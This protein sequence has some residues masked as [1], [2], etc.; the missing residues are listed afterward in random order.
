[1]PV[2]RDVVTLTPH[3]KNEAPS[4]KQ[5]PQRD[6][7]SLS[8]LPAL[9]PND[10]RQ[11]MLAQH[12]FPPEMLDMEYEDDDQV[13]A[14]LDA[15]D[16]SLPS[17]LSDVISHDVD[18]AAM[19]PRAAPAPKRAFPA[20]AHRS[21]KPNYGVGDAAADSGTG[22]AHLRR[23]LQDEESA[24]CAYQGP[25]HV[26]QDQGQVNLDASLEGAVGVRERVDAL[27]MGMRSQ[28]CPH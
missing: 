3:T 9:S 14:R 28:V 12:R 11:R 21:Q 22:L 1:M 25:G 6:I 23:D 10:P 27:M 2:K 7:V 13:R 5:R 20:A 18:F 24:R 19:R 16:P 4:S 26:E 8:N 15:I 17:V